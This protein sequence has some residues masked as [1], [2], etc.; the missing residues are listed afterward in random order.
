M[1]QHLTCCFLSF[2]LALRLYLNASTG[3]DRWLLADFL[4]ELRTIRSW[5]DE[6]RA[7]MFY[8]TS[9][10]LVYDAQQLET[11]TAANS[12]GVGVGQPRSNNN[13]R[14]RMIDFAHV[15]PAHG[16]QDANY[17]H[18]LENLIRIF[19]D[20]QHEETANGQRR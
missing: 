8:A 14:V 7:Y 15:Y 2:P 18:G 13:V 5:F 16:E 3:M 20:F 17:L 10:L 4:R 1:E 11:A 9:L 6:Q 19:Q 12:G